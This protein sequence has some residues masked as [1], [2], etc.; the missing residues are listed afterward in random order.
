MVEVGAGDRDR[1]GEAGGPATRDARLVFRDL[2]PHRRKR[3]IAGITPLAYCGAMMDGHIVQVGRTGHAAEV[4]ERM[5]TATLA[6]TNDLRWAA[7]LGRDRSADGQFVYAVT[8]TGVFCRPS[9]PSRRPRPDRVRFFETTTAAERAGYRACRR[10]HP[11]SSDRARSSADAIDRASRYLTEHFDEAVPL[12]TLARVAQLSPAYLHREFKRTLGVS[13]REYQAAC[14]AKRFRKQL[15]AG[16]A[17]TAAIYEAGYGSPSRIYESPPTGRGMQPAAYRRGG[18]GA[19]VGFTTVRCPLGWLLVAA[20]DR[21]VCAVKLGDSAEVLEAELRCEFSSSVITPNHRVRPEWITALVERLRG[22]GRDVSLPL[23]VRGT[24]FQ[25]RVWRALQQIP[26]GETRSYSDIARA[27]GKPSAV[28]AVANACA[29]NPVCLVVP[30]HRVVAKS[31]GLGGYRWGTRRK[32]RL[33]ES[34]ARRRD[35]A[36]QRSGKSK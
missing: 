27:V 25:W 5:R 33:L 28:R 9:C 4:G 6:A 8:S 26:L 17:V 14:R 21:G 31:G 12:T 10:C 22:S 34:E 36:R 16:R 15:Q 30:C 24:A 13:P 35:A 20:T 1:A 11:T 23:D 2:T 18:A 7:V 29:S 3:R 32:E 19:D